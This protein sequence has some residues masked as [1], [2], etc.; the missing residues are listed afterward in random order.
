MSEPWLQVVLLGAIQGVTEFLPISS[1]GHL[2]LVQH[3][4]GLQGPQLL[5]DVVL[6]A[7]TL[8]ATVL[9]FRKDLLEIVRWLAGK[10]QVQGEFSRLPTGK[11]VLCLVLATAVTAV[12]GV[13]FHDR[14]ESLFEGI[15][16]LGAFWLFTGTVLWTTRWSRSEGRTMGPVGAIVVGLAQAVALA[17][18]I[19]RSGMT[20]A[21]GLL[22]GWDRRWAAT[23]SFLLAMPAVGGA[24]LLE[25]AKEGIHN[26]PWGMLALGAATSFLVGWAILKL[27]IRV[28]MVG[29]FYLFAWYCWALGLAVGLFSLF[30]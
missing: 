9:V 14:I 26:P 21:A 24:V 4:L 7:G 25:V 29:R 28:V 12:L 10:G 30:S 27:L 11:M 23:F 20:I 2:A 16:H 5:L 3:L 6:H 8:A 1:S 22:L 13:L 17:P 15:G 18:G 19:S